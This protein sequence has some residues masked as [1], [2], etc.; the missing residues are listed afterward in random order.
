MGIL[1]CV[2]VAL[3][4]AGVVARLHTFTV[5]LGCVAMLASW[6]CVT[7]LGYCD[8]EMLDDLFCRLISGQG[9]AVVRGNFAL[10]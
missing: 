2:A 6:L 3:Y 7:V 5:A 9:A 4:C 10:F 8:G 1:C